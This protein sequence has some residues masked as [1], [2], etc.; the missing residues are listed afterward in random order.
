M[1]QADERVRFGIPVEDIEVATR[2][3]EGVRDAL[4]MMGLLAPPDVKAQIGALSN[5]LRDTVDLIRKEMP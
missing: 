4:S 2:R 5:E 3:I 1:T